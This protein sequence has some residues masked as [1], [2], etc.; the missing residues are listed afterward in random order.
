MSGQKRNYVDLPSRTWFILSAIILLS[1]CTSTSSN[2][3][4][5][6]VHTTTIPSVTSTPAIEQPKASPFTQSDGILRRIDKYRN[7]NGL[8]TRE[9][10]DVKNQVTP[11]WYPYGFFGDTSIMAFAVHSYWDRNR[12]D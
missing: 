4:P 6:T 10:L 2:A 9:L 8:D 11:G 3:P 12:E 1:S 5:Q 7:N